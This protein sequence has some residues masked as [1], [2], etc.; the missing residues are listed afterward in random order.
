MLRLLKTWSLRVALA[1]VIA[2]AVLVAGLATS[3]GQRAVLGLGGWMASSGDTRVKIGQL[4]GSLFS[5]GHIDR[6]SLSDKRG[7]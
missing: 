4:E 1:L 5:E 6:I 3:P 7:V 2:V